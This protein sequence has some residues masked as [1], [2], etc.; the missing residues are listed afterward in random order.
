MLLSAAVRFGVAL[1]FD[2]PWIAPDEMIYGLVGQSLWESGTLA[3]RDATVPYYSLLTPALVGLPLTLSD[4]ARGVAVAQA[5]QAL[6]MSLV[7]V[8]VY[9]WGTRLVGVRWALAAAVLAVLPPALWYGGLLMTE[10]LFYPLVVAALLALA[11][12]L[13]QPTLERQGLFLLL[14]TAAAAVRLQ[15]LLLLPVL[16]V[17]VG[18]DAWFARSTTIVRRI[19]P[20]L[21][22]IGLS[23]AT[24][25]AVY[26]L[27][28]SDLLGAYG[29]LAQ[30][31]PDSTGVLA[32]LTWHSGAV[33]AMT[34]GLPL[35][36][37]ATLAVLAAVHG[38]ENPSVRAFLAVTTAYVVL[39]VGQVSAFA[40][41]YLDHVSER[42]VVTALPLV[43]LGLCLWIA[44]G[45]P[46][47]AP[48]VLPL[49]LAATAA[50]V[51][52]PR[53]R[54]GTM[55]SAHDALT[56][57]PLGEL[58]DK[59]DLAFRGVLLAL[60]LVLIGVFILIPQRL[61]AATAVAVALGF[62]AAS[63]Q[64]AREI[65]RLSR[66]ERANDFGPADRQWVD[67]AGVAPVLHLDTGEQ[68]S[69]SVARAAFWNRSIRQLLRLE[70]VPPQ[71][72]PQAPV[73]IRTDGAL[74]DDSGREVS[75][76]HVVLPATIALDGERL[77]SSPPT[78]IAPGSG[79]WRIN[80][81]LRLVS[82]TEGFT[83][84]GDFAR[85]K[86]VV[87]PCG[88]GALELTLLGKEGLP[89]RISVNGFPWRTVELA[90]GDL[91]SG[92]VSSLRPAGQVIPCLFELKSKGLVGSTR[93]EWLS[94]ASR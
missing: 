62:V 44:R 72:L 88:P 6:A 25:V 66:V 42:Y 94:R 68:P 12:M 86:I 3:I 60:G 1:T 80:E 34:M 73:S 32:Q 75:A 89:V 83:P 78:D 59:G 37:T 7:A 38:E 9:L 81:P 71:A 67:R 13:E 26:A 21:A 92:A 77:T 35:L 29:E 63:V 10:A 5:L 70:G 93:V 28:R 50:L 57:L 74:V 17:A 27:G 4:V 41:E 91:W 19:A 61:L 65:D 47:P 64:A 15:A 14:V 8:P 48:V 79:L 53:S 54:V 39:L 40:V 11:R 51:T 45:G 22:L 30:T 33:L 90:P 87:Y 49:A 24:L 46:R 85:A 84:I 58:A 76:P 16:L 36:A 31:T 23:T 18:L 20:L 55:S 43:L 56:L 52:L 82:R 2:V 69:T